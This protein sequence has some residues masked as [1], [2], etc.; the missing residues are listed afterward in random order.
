MIIAQWRLQLGYGRRGRHNIK[1]PPTVLGATHGQS[2]LG[3]CRSR[4]SESDILLCGPHK[5]AAGLAAFAACH[6]LPPRHR[7]QR[8]AAGA[9]LPVG[10]EGGLGALLEELGSSDPRRTGRNPRCSQSGEEEQGD[11]LG[12]LGQSSPR[13]LTYI[14]LPLVSDYLY[15]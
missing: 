7:P 9:L 8:P 4:P 14:H 3:T 12:G 2:R 5:E 15:F 11:W 6:A 10:E 1:T 13:Q